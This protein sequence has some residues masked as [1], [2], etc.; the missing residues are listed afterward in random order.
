[1]TRLVKSLQLTRQSPESR[2]FQLATC[3]NQ[4][5]PSNRTLVFRAMD[6]RRGEL[7]VVSDLRTDKIADLRHN[8][9]GAICWYFSDTREQYRFDVKSTIMSLQDH[10][11]TLRAYWNNMSEPGKKQFLW[12]VPKTPRSGNDPLKVNHQPNDPPP[13]FCVITFAVVSGDY[14]CLKGNPQHRELYQHQQGQWH[15]T[16]VIP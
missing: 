10:G 8:C 6:K 16:S 5:A 9:K 7:S 11:D 15:V 1:M 4:G 14:L 2:Y 13:H 3:N 12:G